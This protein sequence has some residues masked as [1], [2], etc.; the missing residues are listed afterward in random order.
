MVMAS[1]ADGV[2]EM[3]RRMIGAT[4]GYEAE[5]GIIRVDF[6]CSA[7]YNLIHGSD[8]PEFT[9]QEFKLLFSSSGIIDYKLTDENWLY[10]EKD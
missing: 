6:V 7:R 10:C 5:Q 1:E 3:E 8:S 4:L 2:I 9:E